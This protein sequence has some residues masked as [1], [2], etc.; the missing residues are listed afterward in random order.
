MFKSIKAIASSFLLTVLIFS[1]GKETQNSTQGGGKFKIRYTISPALSF[2]TSS[3]NFFNT[4]A[5]TQGFSGL[6]L[7]WFGNSSSS[8]LTTIE[9]VEYSVTKGQNISIGHVVNNDDKVCRSLKIEGLI[10]G[11]VFFSTT[12]LLGISGGTPAQ[13]TKCADT[14]NNSVNFI[15]P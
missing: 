10:N 7:R 9:T 11:N 3:G 12:K 13:P 4:I 6:N 15:I 8:D 1:C 14:D 2:G 5:T